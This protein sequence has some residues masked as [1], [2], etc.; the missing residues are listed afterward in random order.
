MDVRTY[1]K[2]LFE[3]L[4]NCSFDEKDGNDYFILGDSRLIEVREFTD[5]FMQ[6]WVNQPEFT[7]N[8]SSLSPVAIQLLYKN[9]F[10]TFKEYEKLFSST[11]GKYDTPIFILLGIDNELKRAKYKSLF[12][13]DYDGYFRCM[14]IFNP[15]LRS[16][17]FQG[18]L[19]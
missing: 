4:T 16:F 6:A 3:E 11:Q 10:C 17:F 9:R 15:S 8:T 12:A 5:R 1:G 14:Q 7:T 13:Q 18:I 19:S 2:Q